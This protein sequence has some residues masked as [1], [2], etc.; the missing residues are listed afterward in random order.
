MR[1]LIYAAG[2]GER[3]RPLTLATPK[4]LLPVAGK[5]LILWQIEALKRAGIVELVVNLSWLGAQI[6]AALG[7]GADL[8]VSIRYSEEGPE[9]LETGGGMRAA[10]PWLGA[11]PFVAV[12]AD[13]W[14]EFDYSRLPA[15]GAEDLAALLLV[16]NPEHH[17]EGDFTLSGDRV[18]LPEGC[19]QTLTFAGIGVYRPELVAGQAPGAF[20]LGPLLKAAAAAGRVAGQL[21]AGRWL[22]VGSIERLALA[23]QWARE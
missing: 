8:G 18:G 2:R 7:E 16:P 17:P 3:M 1:A 14:G 11:A 6:R 21:H 23:E 19:R 15:L 20:K 13:L 22:D 4:P 9:P 12:N 5:P 10:L